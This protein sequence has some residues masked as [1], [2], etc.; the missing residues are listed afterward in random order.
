[1]PFDKISVVFYFL[2]HL[3]VPPKPKVIA[4]V[5]FCFQED[6]GRERTNPDGFFWHVLPR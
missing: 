4:P 6:S 3:G 2:N 5:P 1:M